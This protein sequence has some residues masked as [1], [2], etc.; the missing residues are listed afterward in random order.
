MVQ[1][2]FQMQDLNLHLSF[3]GTVIVNLLPF[4]FAQPGDYSF[5]RI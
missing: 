5:P 3:T 2:R 4:S 1:I